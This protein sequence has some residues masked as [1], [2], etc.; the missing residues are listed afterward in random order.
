MLSRVR[1]VIVEDDLIIQELHARYIEELGH[2]V[3]ATFTTAQEVVTFFRSYA[4]DLIL[5]DVRLEND[6]DGIEAVRKIQ[7]TYPVQVVYIT[8]NTEDSNYLRAL[9]TNMNGFMTKPVSLDELNLVV[10]RINEISGS[11]VYAQKIQS[12]IFPRKEALSRIF[13]DS[14]FIN[15]PLQLL[16]GDFP[17]LVAENVSGHIRGGLGD[18]TGHGIPAA[19]MSL[20][21]YVETYSRLNTQPG[22]LA[23]IVL[24]LNEF[25]HEHV[26]SGQS[27]P[28]AI[29]DSFDIILWE[30]DTDK[31]LI[32]VTGCK[33]KCYHYQAESNNVVVHKFI[34]KDL[35][36]VLTRDD[37]ELK[38]IS[39]QKGD[40]FYFCSDGVIDQFG[41][42]KSKKLMQAG[43]SEMIREVHSSESPSRIEAQLNLL[44]RSWQ[45]RNFQADDML[46]M[47]FKAD[48]VRR[49]K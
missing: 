15:R 8:G 21:C 4:A 25:M 24:G 42:P 34:G 32:H 49:S 43:F 12:A 2:E 9:E 20:L 13:E 31:S 16:T 33:M 19:L 36:D 29:R 27:G 48:S 22:S 47:G 6:E 37:L 5:M 11:I 46:L 18:C 10:D 1:V 44:M 28:T 14:V 17:L 23:E 26:Y 41:G 38:S 3:V 45:G 7:E 30:L 39:Y 40:W 35:S